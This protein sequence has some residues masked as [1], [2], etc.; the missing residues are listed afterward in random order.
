MGRL[1]P[2]VLNPESKIWPIPPLAGSIVTPHLRENHGLF[3]APKGIDSENDTIL[4]RDQNG[5]LVEKSLEGVR[6]AKTL[7]MNHRWFVGTTRHSVEQVTNDC[8]INHK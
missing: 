3:I 6:G 4:Q 5:K 7:R 1:S 2:L 8:N